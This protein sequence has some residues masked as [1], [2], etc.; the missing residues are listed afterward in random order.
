MIKIALIAAVLFVAPSVSCAFEDA[1]NLSY[2]RFE[3]EQKFF[4]VDF[5]GAGTGLPG[6]INSEGTDYSRRA[7]AFQQAQMQAI[8]NAVNTLERTFEF[9]TDKLNNP[10]RQ[11]HLVVAISNLSDVSGGGVIAAADPIGASGKLPK[12][13]WSSSDFGGRAT[14]QTAF[15]TN[16]E[17]VL[18]YGGAQIN[19][20]SHTEV[21]PYYS[22][23]ASKGDA[24]ILFNSSWFNGADP[25]NAY[26]GSDMETVALH[27][28]GHTLGFIHNSN[29]AMAA[30]I[31]QQQEGLD[32]VY[33][34]NGDK[35][36]EIN[37]G[38]KPEMNI[39][40][41]FPTMDHLSGRYMGDAMMSFNPPRSAHEYSD[42]DLA[43]FQDMGW[44]IRDEAWSTYVAV[45]EPSSSILSLFGLSALV[46][47]RI[48]RK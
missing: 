32:S 14:G 1:G 7:E 20:W 24:Y 34:F 36:M 25:S 39:S 29:S 41:G 8:M 37:G 30:F 47:R 16:F 27:E 10:A 11:A 9:W 19:Y 18:K 40:N 38:Q 13:T 12:T 35:A 33:Y 44:K 23:A 15:M 22:S 31:D 2:T 43:M 28:L 6:T 3:S 46:C 45:P 42:L 48:R 17:A 4:K 21:N 5:L 26:I